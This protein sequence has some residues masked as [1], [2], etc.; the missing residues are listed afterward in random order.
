MPP[1]AVAHARYLC[2]KLCRRF[3]DVPVVVGLWDAQGDL[4]RA[5][6]R[7]LEVGVS[8]VVSSAAG[9]VEQLTRLRQPMLQGVRGGPAPVVANGEAEVRTP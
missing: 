5:T 4:Q 3:P 6:D 7:L 8:H 1:S 9:A 2:K